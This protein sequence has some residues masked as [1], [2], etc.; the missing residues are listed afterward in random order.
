MRRDVYDKQA[1][2]AL[3]TYGAHLR[4]ARVRTEER[5]RGLKAELG[6]YGVGVE[7]GEG[8]ERVMREMARVY[9]QMGRQMQDTKGDL[10]RL[11]RG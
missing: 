5:V 4:D 1:I 8:K 9:G 2:Q 10:D 11:R 7:G 6:E 3:R